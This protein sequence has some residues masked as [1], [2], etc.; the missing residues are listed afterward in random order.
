MSLLTTT[1]ILGEVIRG[2]YKS[3]TGRPRQGYR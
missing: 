3:D 1:E 2:T